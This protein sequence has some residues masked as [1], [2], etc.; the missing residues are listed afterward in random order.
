M[1]PPAVV[2]RAVRKSYA[3]RPALNALT[4][5]V[6]AGEIFGFAGPNGAGKTTAMRVIMGLAG[7]DA[8]TVQVCGARPGSRQALAA[9]G[10][11]IET[12]AL[13][14]AASGL[15]HLRA[16][17]R[18]AGVGAGRA[19]EVLDLVG[20]G[21]A[22]SKKTNAYSL[23]MKQR[24]GVATALLKNPRLLLLDE[25]A[26]G[27]DPQGMKDMRTMLIDLRAAGHTVLLSSH[28]LG[29]VEQVADRIGIVV[30]GRMV[31]TE[32]PGD[33]RAR[34]VPSVIV[35]ARPADRVPRV[36]AGAGIVPAAAIAPCDAGFTVVLRE[37]GDGAEEEDAIVRRIVEILVTAGL[38]VY[39]VEPVRANLADVFLDLTQ[40]AGGSS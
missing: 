32:T 24:L 16:V 15:D 38:S 19:E 30:A 6:H 2:M 5:E 17:G 39:R 29:E 36:L 27:L 40:R 21:G 7:V 10:A 13:Y 37:V 31:V 12:P 22:G 33:L 18:W 26:N 35:D 3:G 8:G 11:L 34:A 23:G 28:L 14:P 9:A 4:M 1:T 20:L 25:P